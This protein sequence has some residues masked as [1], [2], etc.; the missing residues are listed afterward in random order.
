MAL[1]VLFAASGCRSVTKQAAWSPNQAVLPWAE[2]QG[3]QVTVHNVRNTTYR[4]ADDYTV[5]HYDKTY[6]L[7]KL[8]TVDFVM[9]PLQ[10]V[11]GGAH[12]FLSFG[13]SNEDYVGVSV[14]VRRKEGEEFDIMQ[15]LRKPYPL[16]YVV[17][18]ERD[19]IQLRTIHWLEDVYMYQ[20]K[21][22]PDQVR[23]LFVD[24]MKR[25]NKLRKE[26]EN[27]H[28]VTNNCTT[29]IVRHVNNIS[30]GAIP[31]GYNV[32][33]PAYSDR[34]AYHLNLIQMDGSFERT[35]QEARI[36]EVAYIYRNDPQ[37]SAQI[38]AHAG[39]ALARRPRSLADNRP[40]AGGRRL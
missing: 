21:A 28:V 12:T 40:E 1:A 11:P 35:K 34:L 22:T 17:G 2:F 9:V 30:P 26:P 38:R 33:F 18:D 15:S 10:D 29:N 23:A 16:M 36:N 19:L 31:Y 27:Y 6:D 4:S 20:A 32:L 3:N 5:H 39:P 25:A 13:F 7:E 24:V 14:E 8:D 37:F